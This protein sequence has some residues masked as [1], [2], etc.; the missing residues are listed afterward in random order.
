MVGG[1]RGGIIGGILWGSQMWDI[2][3]SDT[4]SIANHENRP[5]SE[6]IINNNDRFIT[7]TQVNNVC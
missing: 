3:R 5:S 6:G 2:N 7:Y 1:S 4:I